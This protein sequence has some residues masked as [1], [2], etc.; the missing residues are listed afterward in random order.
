VNE[1]EAET[2]RRIF[3]SDPALGSVRLLGDQLA[4]EGVVG[5]AGRPLA[6]GTL[7]R[8]PRNRN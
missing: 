1:A 4:R 6:C 5:K 7:F 8:L 3:R 2:V